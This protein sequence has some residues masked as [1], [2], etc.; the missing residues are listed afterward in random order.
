MNK[1]HLACVFGAALLGATVCA[2]QASAYTP[3]EQQFLIAINQVIPP[4]RLVDATFLKLG[5]QACAV[6]RS[7]QDVNAAK[8]AVWE[9]YDTYGY[10]PL[11][12]AQ[13]GSI[14]HEAADELCPDVDYW[15]MYR[16]N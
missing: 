6:M 8:R 7:S 2:P 13:V 15:G 11:A 14:V 5:Y 1:T 9:T 3:E 16:Q 10:L 4:P 12:G